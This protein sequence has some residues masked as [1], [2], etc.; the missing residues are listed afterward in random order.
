MKNVNY[1]N[2]KA[3]MRGNEEE[4]A[5]R[6]TAGAERERERDSHKGASDGVSERARS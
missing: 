4:R 2:N 3:I 6:R 5:R 1:N